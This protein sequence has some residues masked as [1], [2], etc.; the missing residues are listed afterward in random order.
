LTITNDLG[1]NTYG[2]AD[3]IVIIIHGKFAHTVREIMQE[4]LNVVT[5][6]AANEGLKISPHKTAIIPFTNRKRTEGLG[7]LLLHGKELKMLEEVKYLGV[8]FD[9]KLNWNQHLQKI[10]RKTQTTSAVVRCT[11]GKTWGLRPSMVHWLHTRVIRPS[12]LYGALVWWPKVKQKT[13]KTRQYS[14]NRLSSYYRGYE[15]DPHCSN[16][17]ASE[18]DSAEYTDH[19][20]SEAGTLQ[21][22]YT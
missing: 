18:S 2:Y 13:T 22:A 14:K 4:A 11:C 16:G 5:K 21:A 3:N 17:G 19:G 1:F 12:I 10:I 9:S 8:T 6:W 20:G 15:I 7:P